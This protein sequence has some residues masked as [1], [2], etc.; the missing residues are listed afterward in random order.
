MKDHMKRHV[1]AYSNLPT[2]VPLTEILITWLLIEVTHPA[3]WFQ[4]V[5]WLLMA[6][7]AIGSV[8]R[9]RDEVCVDVVGDDDGEDEEDNEAEEAARTELIERMRNIKDGLAKRNAEH[10]QACKTIA[11]MHAAAVGEVRGPFIGPVE[12]V[13]ALKAAHDKLARF[14]AYVH[15]RLDA[16]GVPVDP[17]SAHK[18]E[19][20]RIGGRLDWLLASHEEVKARLAQKS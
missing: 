13:A 10:D 19:G 1:I 15:D 20:C 9:M 16:A 2:S 14:K 7:M 6:L 12:D 3:F 5:L 4:V 8:L 11:D 17:E 18:A